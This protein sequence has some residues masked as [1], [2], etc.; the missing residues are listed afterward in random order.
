[1]QKTKFISEFTLRICGTLDF[2]QALNNAYTLLNSIIRV[3]DIYL[4]TFGEDFSKV[5]RVCVVCRSG[6]NCCTD[7]ISVPADMAEAIKNTT[8]DVLLT[9]ENLKYTN[10]EE[11]KVKTGAK[12]A[13]GIAIRVKKEDNVVAFVILR[14][15]EE[16]I[17][18]QEHVE[19]LKGIETPLALALSN[20]F[21]YSK[22]VSAKEELEEEFKYLESE[23][24]NKQPTDV[25]GS[26]EGIF[27]ILQDVNQVVGL[28]NNVLI[29]GDTGVGKEVVANYIH[30]SSNFSNGPFVKIDCGAIPES[31]I[32]SELFGY[33]RGAFTG[34]TAPKKGKIERA[35]GGT[36]FF[37]E[38]GELPIQTQTRLLRALQHKEIVRLGGSK[39]IKV[40]CRIVAATNRDLEKMVHKGEFREDLWYRLNVFP[41]Y[42]PPLRER[43][44][45]I[46][47]LINYMLKKK[48]KTLGLKQAPKIDNGLMQ[49]LVNYDWPGNVREMENVIERELILNHDKG[50]LFSCILGSRTIQPTIRESTIDMV[51]DL[52]TV[53]RN[54][55]QKVLEK[56][57]GKISGKGGAAELL[58]LHPNTLRNKMI[59]LGMI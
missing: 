15:T 29:T 41:V 52:D 8:S 56:V 46:P 43:K 38:I 42:I 14:A 24:L 59:K 17:Y 21:E 6:F 31:L 9:S 12:G 23:L 10:D 54:H 33:E 19:F 4:D 2:E 53:V 3:D 11:F 7:T 48:C 39:P 32:E 45:D 13:S 20:Y 44:S 49:M 26:R 16:D 55:I 28:N 27:K 50:L 51:T 40:D 58:G 36:L 22:L 18:T 30:K 37:D 57:G 35:E 34:A 1:M 25:I 47:V 5:T